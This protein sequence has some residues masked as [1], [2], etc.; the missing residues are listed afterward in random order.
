MQTEMDVDISLSE[1][2]E[3]MSEAYVRLDAQWR[4]EYLNSR[5]LRLISKPKDELIGKVLWDVF[6]DAA[7]TE[8]GKALIKAVE[9]GEAAKF[10]AYYPYTDRWLKVRVHPSSKGISIFYTNITDRV[11]FRQSLE[12]K[13]KERTFEL[14]ESLA[15]EKELN[16]MKSRLVSI[17]SHE[18]RSPLSTILSSVGLIETYLTLAQPENIHKHVCRV[19]TSVKHLSDLLNDF[20]SLDKLEQGKVRAENADFNL[21]QFLLET[22]N[23]LDPVL[24][25]GQSIKFSFRGKSLVHTDNKIIHN[26]V[27]NL[28]TNAIKYSNDE[29]VV[30]AEV[31]KGVINITVADKGIGIPVDEQEHLFSKYYR[32]TNVGGI[33]GTGLGLSIV[34]R[35]VETLGGTIDFTSSKGQG[36][37]FMVSLPIVSPH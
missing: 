18:F 30:T 33:Q 12:A 6:P 22:L 15:R 14:A 31:S 28:V 29:I 23:E 16:D 24:K 1:I 2:L 32:A 11:R 13:V 34:K 20:L 21:Q 25:P 37:T 7:E 10:E 3:T 8:I 4:Y 36:T 17:A 19:K 35:Y 5:A 27:L 26:I 9:L